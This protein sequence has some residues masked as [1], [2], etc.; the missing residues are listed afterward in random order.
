M[1]EAFCVQMFCMLLFMGLSPVLKTKGEKQKNI[2]ILL[3][4]V[5]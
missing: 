2:I 5:I 1:F 3:L 4:Y